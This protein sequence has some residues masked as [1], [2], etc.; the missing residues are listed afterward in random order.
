MP[1]ADTI[2]FSQHCDECGAVFTIDAFETTSNAFRI[3]VAIEN[4]GEHGALTLIL[5]G[6]QVFAFD[7]KE[8]ER[9]V[10]NYPRVQAQNR[11]SRE[12][13]G[14]TQSV[15]SLRPLAE[16]LLPCDLSPG[17]SWDGWFE[18]T[19]P[20]P[21]QAVS[22]LAVVGMFR[23]EIPDRVIGHVSRD[24]NR[25]FIS[26]TGKE[27]TVAPLSG[28]AALTASVAGYLKA[29]WNLCNLGIFGG[30]MIGIV[31]D[32][33]TLGVGFIGAAMGA[34]LGYQAARKYLISRSRRPRIQSSSPSSFD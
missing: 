17:K 24:P 4:T 28:L 31:V 20:L 13:Y 21:D 3:H 33:A 27:V 34:F 12:I 6:S 5:D 29:Q 18:S 7:A 2:Y 23:Q 9:W 30:A 15:F 14:T 25:P 19:R 22:L 10:R 16:H 32:D 1:S 26:L 11:V 8:A